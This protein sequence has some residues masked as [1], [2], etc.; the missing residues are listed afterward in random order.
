[1]KVTLIRPAKAESGYTYLHT[2]YELMG[3]ALPTPATLNE[4]T[5]HAVATLQLVP[6]VL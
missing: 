1:M 6:V 3:S 5:Q 2:R 4:V